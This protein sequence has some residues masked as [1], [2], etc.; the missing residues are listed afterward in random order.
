MYAVGAH[1]GAVCDIDRFAPEYQKMLTHHFDVFNDKIRGAR[2]TEAQ[3][4]LADQGLHFFDALLDF[5]AWFLLKIH[6]RFLGGICAPLSVGS[7]V[8]YPQGKVMVA[9]CSFQKQEI[10]KHVDRILN[11]IEAEKI[12]ESSKV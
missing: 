3:H 4:L 10:Q 5:S 7:A 1:G 8:G 11:A 12:D 2:H 9:S 6:R